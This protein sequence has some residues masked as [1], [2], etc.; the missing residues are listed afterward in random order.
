MEYIAGIELVAKQNSNEQFE[1]ISP[2]HKSYINGMFSNQIELQKDDQSFKI[3]S[4]TLNNKLIFSPTQSIDSKLLDHDIISYKEKIL[5]DS[6]DFILSKINFKNIKNGDFKIIFDGSEIKL[7]AND[8]DDKT[9]KKI[10]FLSERSSATSKSLKDYSIKLQ[11]KIHENK[12]VDEV[13]VN[14]IKKI[15]HKNDVNKYISHALLITL[16]AS[17]FVMSIGLGGVISHFTIPIMSLST[18]SILLAS[19]SLLVIGGLA[20]LKIASKKNKKADE[21]LKELMN[22]TRKYF[23]FSSLNDAA[24]IPLLI[25]LGAAVL[26]G[27]IPHLALISACLALPVALLTILSGVMQLKETINAFINANNLQEPKKAERTLSEKIRDIEK[28][29]LSKEIIVPV[30]NMVYIT[31]LFIC[32]FLYLTN[33]LNA[34]LVCNS[35]LGGVGLIVAAI[36]IINA[37]KQKKEINKINSKIPKEVIK[38]IQD[39]FNLTKEEVKKIKEKIDSLDREKTKEY[40][41]YKIKTFENK[42]KK[43]SYNE[44]LKC[45]ENNK[46]T[47]EEIKQIIFNE[48]IAQ[49]LDKKHMQLISVIS[50]E[51][52]KEAL[53]LITLNRIVSSKEIED[54]YLKVFLKMRKEMDVKLAAEILKL[55][56]IYIIC[57]I[58]PILLKFLP[59]AAYYFFMAFATL[60]DLCINWKSRFRNV[61]SVDKEVDFDINKTLSESLQTQKHDISEEKKIKIA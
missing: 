19:G 59:I 43:T 17:F 42:D 56:L 52:F 13:A 28:F 46:I 9:D 41:A 1:A 49:A 31:F 30:L 25:L 44:Y 55:F 11:D 21:Y 60:M 12:I 50:I 4:L 15:N 33:H 27:T 7:I 16:V 61:P 36:G 45:L 35:V 57:A 51:T 22:L 37:F 53:E 6:R 48:E 3:K 14:K 29:L 23:L 5:K 32:G 54:K 18:G 34:A 58:N 40:I 47:L 24:S 2:K 39:K 26:L 8:N 10:K 20:V 38:Y